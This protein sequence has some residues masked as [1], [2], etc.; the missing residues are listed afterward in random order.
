MSALCK[1][2]PSS[3]ASMPYTTMPRQQ[4]S[5]PEQVSAERLS[6]LNRVQGLELNMS[7]TGAVSLPDLYR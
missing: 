1:P 4:W 6:R 2:H 3:L 7:S 5:R